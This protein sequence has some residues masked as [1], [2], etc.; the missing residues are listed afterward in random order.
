MEM[1]RVDLWT[2]CWVLI[3]L[4]EVSDLGMATDHPPLKTKLDNNVE[5]E[6]QFYVTFKRSCRRIEDV[7]SN[8]NLTRSPLVVSTSGP[9]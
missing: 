6:G 2:P 1:L 5:E 3:L 8:E 7:C 9:L 4:G